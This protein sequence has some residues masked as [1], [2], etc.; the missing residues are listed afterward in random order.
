MSS[1][2]A[3]YSIGAL[4]GA[5]LVGALII[6]AGWGDGSG[7]AA[8]AVIVLVLG[9]WRSCNLLAERQADR[10]PGRASP[11]PTAPRSASASLAFLCF[12][13]EGAVTDWSALFL[14]DR[15]G[16]RRRREPAA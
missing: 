8:L 3:F 15:Q 9:A 10:R 13:I 5:A 11:C 2:H 12:A 4:G 16:G 7:A 1:F 14:A 6:A